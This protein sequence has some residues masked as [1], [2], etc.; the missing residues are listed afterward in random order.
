MEVTVEAELEAMDFLASIDRMY[1]NRVWGFLTESGTT[2]AIV[3]DGA[4]GIKAVRSTD[5]V[6]KKG[7]LTMCLHGYHFTEGTNLSLVYKGYRISIEGFCLTYDEHIR[8]ST[9]P[10]VK[11]FH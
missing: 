8:I 2:Y 6:E 11:V 10:V 9:S 7:A 3:Q 5:K 1:S 4:G